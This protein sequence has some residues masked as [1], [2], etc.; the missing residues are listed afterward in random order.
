MAVYYSTLHSPEPLKD[1]LSIS[2]PLTFPPTALGLGGVWHPLLPLRDG[3]LGPLPTGISSPV[4]KT[5]MEKS[6]FNSPSPQD[7]PRLSSFT[8]HHRPVIAVHSGECHLWEATATTTATKGLQISKHSLP[9]SNATCRGQGT[10]S[11]TCRPFD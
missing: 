7:S 10:P 1:F 2:P 8:Q 5:E 4:K 3:D 9:F 11:V 6:P